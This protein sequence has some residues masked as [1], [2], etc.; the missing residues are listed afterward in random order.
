MSNVH[1]GINGEVTTLKA[2]VG[3]E[4]FLKEKKKSL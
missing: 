3:L 1:V 4:C 2:F